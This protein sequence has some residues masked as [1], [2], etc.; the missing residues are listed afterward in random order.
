MSG[1]LEKARREKK[2]L[3]HGKFSSIAFAKDEIFHRKSNI[4]RKP[5]VLEATFYASLIY[6]RL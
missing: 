2:Y 5:G 6:P 4:L 3:F 1:I